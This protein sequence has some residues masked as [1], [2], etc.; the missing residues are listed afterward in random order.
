V[1]DVE[2]KLKEIK[3]KLRMQF[4]ATEKRITDLEAQVAFLYDE[5]GRLWKHLLQQKEKD[6][7]P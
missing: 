7:P 2:S 1:S 5:L 4:Y 3:L 6:D